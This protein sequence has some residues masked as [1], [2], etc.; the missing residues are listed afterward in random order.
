MAKSK[1]FYGL[2]RGST[3]SHTY[4]VLKG[5]Q[6]TKDRVTD[7]ANPKTQAQMIQRMLFAQC[8]K[9]YKQALSN[10]FK[11][12]FEDKKPLES[13]YN[14]FVRHNTTRSI[15]VDMANYNTPAYPSLGN[16]QLTQGSL[17][18]A[19]CEWEDTDEGFL[20]Y[21]D[22]T[23]Q[24][25]TLGTLSTAILSYYKNLQE[26]DIVTIVH[27]VSALG[28]D[29]ELEVDVAPAWMVK[30]FILDVN[31]GTDCQEFFGEE[32]QAFEGNVRLFP[33]FLDRLQMG[34]VTFSRNTPSGLK[35]SNSYMVPS[36]GTWYFI[37]SMSTDSAKRQSA[38][39]WGAG[40]KAI[41]QGGLTDE[42]EDIIYK[43]TIE[44]GR[45]VEN[46]GSSEKLV[47]TSWVPH[48]P[49]MT[50]ETVVRI[51]GSEITYQGSGKWYNANSKLG[52]SFDSNTPSIIV[53][54]NRSRTYIRALI[55]DG[56][57]IQLY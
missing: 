30:Q 44:G 9:F 22:T 3:K 5:Q 45:Y 24:E 32:F 28:N 19:E 49:K 40:D 1:S 23:E 46:A 55:I 27:N 38:I 33:K 42:G 10:F 39:S 12:A 4:S 17:G 13:D 41:L 25:Q 2:R 51:N 35:V 20:L 31:D 29:A 52:I 7:V 18:M 34:S 43:C 11:F 6:V 21:C 50:S 57:D 15:A 37:E 54:P 14:A 8:V 16:F 36:Q 26:G 53:G 47:A 48:A 56:K